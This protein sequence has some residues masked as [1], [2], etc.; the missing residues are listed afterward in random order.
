[1]TRGLTPCFFDV[2][3]VHGVDLMGGVLRRYNCLAPFLRMDPELACCSDSEFE[4]QGL[5]EKG[6]HFEGVNREGPFERME[7][8]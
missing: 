8:V 6:T 1:M 3:D 5:F 4:I 2:M 7:N